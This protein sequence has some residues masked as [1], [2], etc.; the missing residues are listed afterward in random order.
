MKT[1]KRLGKAVRRIIAILYSRINH[2]QISFRKLPAGK[3]KPAVPDILR[4]CIAAEQAEPL[5][6]IERGEIHILCNTL[7]CQLLCEMTFDIPDRL[8]DLFSPCFHLLLYKLSYPAHACPTFPV[9]FCPQ[10]GVSIRIFYCPSRR[11]L[12]FL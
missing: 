9:L 1:G 8:T 3:G 12:T 5:L 11:D 7:H 10:A 2:P 6:E 4:D